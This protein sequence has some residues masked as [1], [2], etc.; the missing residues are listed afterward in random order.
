MFTLHLVQYPTNTSSTISRINI[1]IFTCK[2]F[3]HLLMSFFKSFT[4]IYYKKAITAILYD[5]KISLDTK[6]AAVTD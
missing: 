5:E 2:P 6:K 1:F 3:Q 4:H